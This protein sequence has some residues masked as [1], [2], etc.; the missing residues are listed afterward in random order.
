M[1]TSLFRRVLMGMVPVTGACSSIYIFDSGCFG[2]IGAFLV[3]LDLFTSTFIYKPQLFSGG[4][5]YE[6][7]LRLYYVVFFRG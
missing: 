5:S 4:G 1:D 3:D 2:Y 6:N 7:N